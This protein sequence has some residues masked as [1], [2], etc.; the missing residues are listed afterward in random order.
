MAS[1]IATR[2][3]TGALKALPATVLSGGDSLRRKVWMGAGAFFLCM[4]LLAGLVV[5]AHV[6]DY[7]MMRD[8]LSDIQ[9][10]RDILDA[11]NGISAERGPANSVMGEEL[12]RDSPSRTRLAKR[13]AENDA[14]LAGLAV[15]LA[16]WSTARGGTVLPETL[17][18]VAAALARARGDVDRVAAA[19]LSQRE[20][21]SVQQAVQRMFEV[22]DTFRTVTDAAA[23]AI[24]RRHEG[25]TAQILVAELLGDLR[26][27]AGRMA[28]EIMPAVT[29]R[30]PLRTDEL[31]A[32]SR[33]RGRLREI[34]AL[35]GGQ[36]SLALDDPR[37]VAERAAVE[38]EFFGRGLA[39][40][41]RIVEQGAVSG[42]YDLTPTA[43]TA[44]Y[45]PTLAPIE[46]LRTAFLDTWVTRSVAARDHAFSMLLFV[47]GSIGLG[48]AT[49]V[50]LA[51]SLQRHVFKPLLVARERVIAL[52]EE[53]DGAWPD[54]ARPRGE[55]RRLFEAI[56]A[57][58]A[59]VCERALLT[60][61]L[62]QQAETDL[63]TGLPNRRALHRAAEEL[64]ARPGAGGAIGLIMI[65][66]DHFKAINDRHGHPAGDEA[67]RQVAACLAEA[68]AAK[69]MAC[70]FGGE[71][72]A[73]LVPS[74]DLDAAVAM[75]RSLRSALL[76]RDMCI[77]P[78]L[79]LR[80]TASFGVAASGAGP[81]S[82]DCLIAAA[83]AALYRA[84]SGGRNRI[85]TM[86]VTGSDVPVAM[87]RAG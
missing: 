49:L 2:L 36:H 17:D 50:A 84:K 62:R 37:I 33:T 6:S 56:A 41:D 51:A 77:G 8:D 73:V 82:W 66:L 27:Y 13:R 18:E 10:F 76:A 71:E 39:V 67:L 74:R 58:Q 22:V 46:R 80:L 83:D 31:V 57:L 12:T 3:A 1:I 63:L 48:M 26:E 75:A 35:I 81:V 29:V 78:G 16:A 45:V 23:D 30:Q 43:F 79:S 40:F 70:R 54:T 65:D 7:W 15:R 14:A 64:L 21:A 53:R 55:M 59:R 86:P 61:Q 47:A 20:I 42:H 87:R 25:I 72:F 11:A 34:W 24:L 28:S 32:S 5:E 68:V 69:A 4:A 85:C 52:A 9:C 44:L 19:P 60:Q 38:A